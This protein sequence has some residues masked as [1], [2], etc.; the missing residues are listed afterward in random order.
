MDR[1]ERGELGTL[2]HPLR[3]EAV[4]ADDPPTLERHH[5]AAAQ[6]R[7]TNPRVA[8]GG[9]VAVGREPQG[10]AL[11]SGIEPAGDWWQGVTSLEIC[12]RLSAIGRVR[13]PGP[14]VSREADSR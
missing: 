6:A 8:A 1:A 9:Q 4:H 14:P 2:T 10:A 12:Y 3:S 11:G 7:E 13:S 5:V